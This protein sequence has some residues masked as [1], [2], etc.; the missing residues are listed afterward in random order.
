MKSFG[1]TVKSFEQPRSAS[2]NREN[3]RA[4]LAVGDRPEIAVPS[5]SRI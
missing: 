3:A 5:V 2:D 1:Q 4:V